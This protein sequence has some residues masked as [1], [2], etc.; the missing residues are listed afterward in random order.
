MIN[1]NVHL[2]LSKSIQCIHGIMRHFVYLHGFS[3]AYSLLNS[4][5]DICALK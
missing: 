3:L 2:D 4:R 1:C 5:C